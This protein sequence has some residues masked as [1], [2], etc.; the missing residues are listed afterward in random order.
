M[1]VNKFKYIYIYIKNIYLNDIKVIENKKYG[2]DNA[3]NKR[4][5]Y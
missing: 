1:E 3:Y 2:S 5:F 4:Q